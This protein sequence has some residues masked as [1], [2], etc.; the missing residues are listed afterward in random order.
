MTLF[1]VLLYTHILGGG[2]SLLLGFVILCLKKGDK[3]HKLLGNLYFY[4]MLTASVFAIPMCYLHPNYFLFIVSIFTIY[5]L[6][7][8]KRYLHKKA[9]SDITKIDW[10]LTILMAIFGTAFIGFGVFHMTK[11]NMFG[12]VFIVFGLISYL[13]VYQDKNN[14]SG[15][16]KVK[17]YFLVAHLQRFIGSYIASVTAFLVVNN[18]VLPSVIAWLLPIVLIVPLIVK[19]TRKYKIDNKNEQAEIR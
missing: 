11:S 9:V 17:N 1:N 8:G 19:W 5:M 18:K 6:L 16:S 3:T 15:K 7:T 12:I 13:F 10:L 4:A 14:F 2:M